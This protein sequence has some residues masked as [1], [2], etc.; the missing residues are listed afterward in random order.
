MGTGLSQGSPPLASAG[1]GGQ[2][3]DALF[4]GVIDLGHRRVQLVAAAGVIPLELAV[5]LGRGIQVLFQ[6]IGPAERLGRYFL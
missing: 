5:D 1:F 6:A 2:V 4:L 3:A